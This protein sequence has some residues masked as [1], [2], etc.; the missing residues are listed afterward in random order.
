MI[1]IKQQQKILPKSL[2][3]RRKQKSQNRQKNKENK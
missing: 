2:R 1:Y 3:Q